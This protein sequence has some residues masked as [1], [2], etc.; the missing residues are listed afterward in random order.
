M[1]DPE[2]IADLLGDL[3]ILWRRNSDLR[4]GQLVAALT[5]RQLDP[6]Y[7]EDDA[8]HDRIKEVLENGWVPSRDG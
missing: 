2:R 6:F 5:P 3:H 8:I 4:L 7:V 1:R